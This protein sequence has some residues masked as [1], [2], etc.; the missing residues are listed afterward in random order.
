MHTTSVPVS[1]GNA[2]SPSQDDPLLC[3]RR[4]GL[5]LTRH[6]QEVAATIEISAA[7]PSRFVLECCTFPS[8][9]GR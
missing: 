3:E 1:C 2:Q 5:R 8:Q 7:G 6:I 9:P 4:L